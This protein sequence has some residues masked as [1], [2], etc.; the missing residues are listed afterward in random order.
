MATITTITVEMIVKVS[1]AILMTTI[2]GS[3]LAVIV[4]MNQDAATNADAAIN[5]VVEISQAFSR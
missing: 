2:V 3:C 4:A 1:E 5:V